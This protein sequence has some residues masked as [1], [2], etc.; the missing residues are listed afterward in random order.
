MGAVAGF[1][2][3]LFGAVR[4][5]GLTVTNNIP[6]NDQTIT[7]ETNYLTNIITFLISGPFLFATAHGMLKA[8]RSKKASPNIIDETKAAFSGDNLMRSLVATIR[9]DVFVFL[10][11]LLFIIPGIYKSIQ[12]SQ[13]MRLLA[14]NDKMTPA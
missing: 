9:I 2:G 3:G 7:Y 6:L 13:T 11:S 5:P 8:A 12:Y 1:I 10:W 4:I 14:D